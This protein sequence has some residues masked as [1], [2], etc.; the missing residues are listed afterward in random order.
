MTKKVKQEKLP[1]ELTRIAWILVIG[2]IPAMLDSTMVN[3]A[4]NKLQLDLNTNLNMIQWAITGYTLALAAAVPITGYLM[5]HFDGKK[6]FAICVALFGAGSVL[7]GF[8]WNVDAFILSRMVQGFF[9]GILV[10]CLTT[11]LFAV[12]P[13][14]KIGQLMAVVGTPMILGPILG[15]VIGGFIVQYLNWHWIFFV[16]IP[17]VIIAVILIWHYLPKMTPLNPTSK[18]DWIGTL[19]LIT[20]SSSFMYGIIKGSEATHFFESHGMWLFC[21]VSL[22]C[23]VAYIIYDLLRKHNTVMPLKFFESRN[24]TAANIG[25][26]LNGLAVN[27]AMLLLPL[28]FQNVRNFTVVEAGMILIPQ[29]LGMLITRPL[30][31]KFIDKVGARPVVLASIAVSLIGSVPLIW[32]GSSTNIW[33][34]VLILFIRG[35]GIGGVFMPLMTDV[36]IGIEPKDVP[37]AGVA[38]RMI[39]NVGSSFGSAVMSAIVTGIVLNYM[40]SHTSVNAANLAKITGYQTGFLVSC[41]ALAVITIPALFLTSKHQKSK[42]S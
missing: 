7:S 23:L 35:L 20:F 22:I 30:A 17:I 6:I 18:L 39:Q 38:N 34:I 12:T 4:I 14:D 31:G 3:I 21:G 42:I 25:I 36:Y 16:N 40:T 8:A 33:W 26:F 32:W 15:P 9:G 24:F 2:A 29:G 27:G 28:Y 5:N 10:T 11:L 13:K 37:G 19:I 1:K 41:I